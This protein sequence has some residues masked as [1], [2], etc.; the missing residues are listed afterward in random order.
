MEVFM[1]AG[2]QSW[3][4]GNSRQ[5]RT[6]DLAT[7]WHGEAVIGMQWE[8]WGEIIEKYGLKEEGESGETLQLKGR[9]DLD[10]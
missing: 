5:E 6:Q 10:C 1:A 4:E 8:C 7:A 3:T 2:K 9:R